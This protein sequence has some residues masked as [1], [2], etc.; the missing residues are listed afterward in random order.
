MFK[1]LYILTFS[2]LFISLM[3]HASEPSGSHN[4]AEWQIWAYSSAAPSFVG[5]KATI[6]GSNG[7][8]LRE[9]SNGWNCASGNPRPVPSQGWKDPH[10]AMPTCHDDVGM[11]WMEGYMSGKKPKIDRDT[12][13]WMLHGDMGED[14]TTPGVLNKSDAKDQS[15]FIVSGPHLMLMPKDPSSLDGLT[16]DFTLGVPYVMFKGTDYAHV[17][18][19][20]EDYYKYQN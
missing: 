6:T 17:M 18:I 13:M 20:V 10:N 3:A 9:G 14:N 12:Y 16:E 11:Q 5:D 7:E 2:S 1:S 4:S 15:Q 8:I 19:P